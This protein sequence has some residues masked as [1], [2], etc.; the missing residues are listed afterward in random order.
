M[1]QR[2]NP[3]KRIFRIVDAPKSKAKRTKT[4]PNSNEICWYNH[5]G[6]DPT[7]F[8]LNSTSFVGKE[9]TAG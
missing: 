4:T 5:S 9:S 3:P 8:K 2:T 7:L 1:F 6:V